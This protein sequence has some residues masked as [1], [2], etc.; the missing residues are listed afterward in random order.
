MNP[1]LCNEMKE[2]ESEN[3]IVRNFNIVFYFLFPA[4]SLCLQKA[5]F[6]KEICMFL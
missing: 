1:T 3:K 4:V 6:L 2:N 5:I